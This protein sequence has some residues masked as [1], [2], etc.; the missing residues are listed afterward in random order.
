MRSR[1]IFRTRSP[2]VVFPMAFLW[3]IIQDSNP[4]YRWPCG[5]S[6][7]VSHR[8]RMK[9]TN[10]KICQ[11]HPLTHTCVL[12]IGIRT[13]SPIQCSGRRGAAAPACESRRFVS[14]ADH[15]SSPS[16]QRTLK[17]SAL[18]DIHYM[19][20]KKNNNNAPDRPCIY[21]PVARLRII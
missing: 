8:E 7:R 17:K 5:I 12:L 21:Y 1:S 9:R 16:L 19:R 3:L 2:P 15:Y 11:V 6:P 14:L 20:E 18:W 13:E 4:K 10:Q